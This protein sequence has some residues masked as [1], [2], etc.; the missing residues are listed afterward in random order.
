MSEE[1]QKALETVGKYV[2]GGQVAADAVDIAMRM[3]EA[4]SGNKKTEGDQ[5]ETQ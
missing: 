2:A 3:H 1:A 5:N 4:Q